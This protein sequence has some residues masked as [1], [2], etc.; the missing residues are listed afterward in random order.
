MGVKGG[1]TTT[2]GTRQSP[3]FV[4]DHAPQLQE[5]LPP[6]WL[7]GL[8]IPGDGGFVPPDEGPGAT[9]CAMLGNVAQGGLHQGHQAPPR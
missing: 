6:F 4:S 7:K 3:S 1:D 2:A 5:D 9:L 8:G